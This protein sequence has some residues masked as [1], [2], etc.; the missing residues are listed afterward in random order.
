[1]KTMVNSLE[2]IALIAIIGLSVMA[3][4]SNSTSNTS[5]TY[6]D[7]QGRW[8]NNFAINDHGYSDFSVT[9]TGREMIFRSADAEGRRNS[10][11][12]TFTFTYTRITFKPQPMSDEDDR[13]FYDIAK[14]SHAIL[15]TGNIKHFPLEP[16]IVSPADFLKEYQQR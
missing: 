6:A 14:A 2:I 3:C 5:L 10:W 4:V 15:L 12:G 9:F 16:F 8:L 1:M 11:P 7:F 13:I